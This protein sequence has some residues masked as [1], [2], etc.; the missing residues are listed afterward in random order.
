[1]ALDVLKN[2]Y[3]RPDRLIDHLNDKLV[4]LKPVQK[5]GELKSFVTEFE[6]ICKLLDQ[7]GQC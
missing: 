7:K 5:I 2:K 4:N 6:K 3:D 1:M